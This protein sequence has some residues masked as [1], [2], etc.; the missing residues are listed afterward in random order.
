MLAG[1]TDGASYGLNII[2]SKSSNKFRL[3]GKSGALDSIHLRAL[4]MIDVQSIA[5]SGSYSIRLPV[6]L[7]RNPLPMSPSKPT[8]TL[9]F[10]LLMATTSSAQDTIRAPLRVH[11]I[12]AKDTLLCL[13]I[14]VPKTLA[15]TLSHV[16][17]PGKFKQSPDSTWQWCWKM[18]DGGGV[19]KIY[20]IRYSIDVNE[21]ST[22]EKEFWI[23]A[24]PPIKIDYSRLS[25]S[26]EVE[27]EPIDDL[28]SFVK[29]PQLAQ[30][31]GIEGRVVVSVL[32]DTTGYVEKVEVNETSHPWFN[33]SAITALALTRFQPGLKDGKPVKVWYTVPLVYKLN[34]RK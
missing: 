18:I 12:F 24:R 21:D 19:K 15:S 32:I 31:V 10:L 4:S 26:N 6:A 27:P 1:I 13:P 7:D 5:S 3:L 8:A 29:Y 30:R 33:E 22:I 23:D 9:F 11:R 25:T 2:T 28:Y 34:K 17:G 14:E 16:S 20:P